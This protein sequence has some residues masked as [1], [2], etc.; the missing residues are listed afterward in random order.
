[1]TSIS[2]IVI[3]VYVN[4][5]TVE[6]KDN[7][8]TKYTFVATIFEDYVSGVIPVAVV[9]INKKAEIESPRMEVNEVCF[10]LISFNNS[11]NIK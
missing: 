6:K 4:R 10:S 2:A 9:K 11:C 8:T 1:M 3:E 5:Q 7:F